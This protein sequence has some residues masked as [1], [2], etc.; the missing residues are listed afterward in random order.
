MVA[1]ATK[2][3]TGP[4]FEGPIDH[5]RRAEMMD[6]ARAAVVDIIGREAPLTTADLFYLAL[7]FS[8]TL[9]ECY[10]DSLHPADSM[11]AMRAESSFLRETGNMLAFSGAHLLET[12]GVARHDA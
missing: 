2:P 6:K 12:H 1:A 3:A 11:N 10:G 8:A 5:A 7:G 4:L 9:G